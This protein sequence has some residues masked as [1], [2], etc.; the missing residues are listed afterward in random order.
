MA[1]SIPQLAWMAQP[2]GHIFWYNRRWYEYTGTTSEQM[3]GWGWQAVHDPDELP[4]VLERWKAAIAEGKPWEDT[5]PL[6]RHDGSMRPH[7]SRAVPMYD[8]EGR[9]MRWFG[10]NTDITERIEAEAALLRAKEAAEAA[11]LAK[12]RFLANM[13]HE[14][15][16]PMNAILGLID[17]ALPKATDPTIKD[18]L[19]TAKGS[20]DLLLTLLNDLLDSAR[21]ESGK[22]E[23][24]SA[25]FS[26][27]QMLNQITRVLAVRASEKGLS[28]YCRVPDQTPDV[29]TGDRM[30]LQ[31]VLLNLAGNAIK[32][33]ERGEVAIS[34]EQS[35]IADA[36]SELCNLTFAVQDTGIGIP[37]A[38]QEHLFQPFT[39][40]DTSTTRRFGGTGLGLSISKSFVEMMGGRIWV[41]SEQGK[42]STFYFNVRLPLAKELLADFE[43]PAAVTTAA[44][45]QLRILLAEDNPA[46]Q[47]LVTYI[48]QDRGHLLEIANDGQ[49]A[50]DRIAQKDYDVILMDVEMPGMNGLEASAAI[51]NR[52]AG[53]RRIPIIAM[54]AHAMASDRE[55]CL[56]HGMD[57]YLSKPID[58]HEMISLIERL[59][60]GSAREAP[61]SIPA[62]PA[63]QKAG[64]VFDPELALKRCTGSKDVLAGMVGCFLQEV[65]DLLPQMREA[66]EKGDLAEVARLGHRLKGTIVYLGA[67]PAEKAAIAVEKIREDGGEKAEAEKLVRALEHECEL[68]ESAMALHEGL[69]A[70]PD[71][72]AASVDLS[73]PVD[74]S[75]FCLEAATQ[76]CFNKRQLLQRMVEYFFKDVDRLL[77]Q[78][79]SALANGD[80]A[81]VG[82]LGHR[83]KGTLVNLVATRATEAAL[84]VERFATTGGQLADAE[85]AVREL[86]RECETLGIV[87]TAY[88]PAN[89][90]PQEESNVE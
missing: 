34:V 18:C 33:T 28:L 69:T 76:R 4:R 63:A 78:M 24:E 39:Q 11:N 44:S 32:F 21:I 58:A 83:F 60:A 82:H 81:E 84:R 86:E 88:R 74:A 65:R 73:P 53:G 2:D 19:Q 61:S 1:E 9:V 22:L 17:V 10:T 5:F 75:I 35:Q 27:R 41:E 55:R 45:T 66:S 59:G 52:E 43:A 68:L 80:V 85:E 6:R 47:K 87:L 62:E 49:Q 8:Q 13:S 36:E 42:G 77:P 30:R 70:T 72:S 29:V 79:R 12:S 7:L 50:I 46:N 64:A 14:L 40:A 57:G 48:L 26:L 56:A 71:P 67:E 20:A 54:T 3:E 51:R 31:Q 16:T 23:L 37:R 89:G 25:P 38:L 15:R 90:P